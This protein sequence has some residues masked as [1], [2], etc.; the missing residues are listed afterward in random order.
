MCPVMLHHHMLLLRKFFIEFSEFS[1]KFKAAI[2]FLAVLLG[3]AGLLAGLYFALKKDYCNCMDSKKQLDEEAM[4]EEDEETA[5]EKV[6]DGEVKV[7]P[8]AEEMT[9]ETELVKE[10]EKEAQ[11]EA[12]VPEIVVTE[13]AFVPEKP[14][15]KRASSIKSVFKKITKPIGKVRFG[16][17][18]TKA[19]K[20]EYPLAPQSDQAY[21]SLLRSD[22]M[23]SFLSGISVVSENIE[24]F[25]EEVSPGRLQATLEYNKKSW[26]LH[27]GVKQAE[28][29]IHTGKEK[30]YWQVHVTF[31]PFKKHRFKT[32]YKSTSTPVFNQTFDVEEIAEQALTQIGVRF[33][34]YGRLGRTGKKKLAGETVVNLD[35]LKD[36]KGK[37][38]EWH[39]LKRK[40]HGMPNTKV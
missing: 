36:A 33:R 32:K 8:Q 12:T 26:T 25:G 24:E 1:E 16:G 27:V 38:T 11:A 5:N 39:I 7:E 17:V 21:G 28:C 35:C 40:K 37:L 6:E 23:E 3:V 31:L 13:T 18:T 9:E 20:E 15:V 29:L 10:Q 34:V 14:I 19:A 2:I 22:S 4:A 30:I